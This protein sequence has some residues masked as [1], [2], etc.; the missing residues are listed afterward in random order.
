MSIFRIGE[1]VKARAVKGV[2]PTCWITSVA[3]KW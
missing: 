2:I 1:N 3:S